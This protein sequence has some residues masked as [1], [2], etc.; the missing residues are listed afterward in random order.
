LQKYIFKPDYQTTSRYNGFK[1]NEITQ[2]PLILHSIE[3]R[4]WAI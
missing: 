4:D 1:I 2:K 3:I